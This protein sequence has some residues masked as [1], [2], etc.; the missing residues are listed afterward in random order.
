M[1]T[2]LSSRN[3]ARVHRLFQISLLL[4]AAHSLLEIIGGIVLAVVSQEAVLR[5]AHWLTRE[6]LL[7]DP[8]DWIAN[9]I[10][11]S[12][13][14]LSLDQKFAAAFFLLSHGI[15]KLFLIIAVLR[16]KPWAYPAFMIALGLL[17][18]YQSYRLSH[19]FSVGLTALTILDAIVLVLAWHEYR[20]NLKS[21]S[22]S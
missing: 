21:Q 13:Q 17:I 15:V 7:E 3:E 18:V 4:K 16:K 2:R 12:A 10:L 5:L 6:E 22:L 1:R 14:N 9:Y 20:F 11:R 19:V 8:R